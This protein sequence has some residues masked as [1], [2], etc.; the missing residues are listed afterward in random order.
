[1]MV[2][3]ATPSQTS[4]KPPRL[5]SNSHRDVNS[6]PAQRVAPDPG[7]MLIFV[8]STSLSCGQLPNE[9]NNPP[10][11]SVKIPNGSVISANKP[12][13]ISGAVNCAFCKRKQA[14]LFP[15]RRVGISYTPLVRSEKSIG[16][17]ELTVPV[18]P[19]TVMV[20]GIVMC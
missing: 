4:I 18:L 20:L 19:P 5:C 8:S 2:E 9:L 12:L 16:V 7:N 3:N 11:T 10:V 13:K 1:M 6:T 15:D 14:I 17:K